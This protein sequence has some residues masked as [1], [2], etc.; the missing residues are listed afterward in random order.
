MIK[1]WIDMG[2]VCNLK[3]HKILFFYKKIYSYHL[4]DHHLQE[5]VLPER[6]ADWLAR[7]RGWYVFLWL[8]QKTI[9]KINKLYFAG[10][11]G[12]NK[13]W[14]DA[15]PKLGANFRGIPPASVGDTCLEAVQMIPGSVFCQLWTSSHRPFLNFLCVNFRWWKSLVYIHFQKR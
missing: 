6:G 14:T 2:K 10:G 12:A 9:Y 1:C 4:R 8:S 3:D 15:Q 13:H 7:W 11:E 5:N